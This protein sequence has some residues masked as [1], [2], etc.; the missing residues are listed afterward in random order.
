MSQPVLF[1]DLHGVLVNTPRIFDEY[2]RIT[3]EHL[4]NHLNLSQKD[5]EDRYD[6]ALALWEKEAFDYL[7]NPTKRKIGRE[8]L[9]FLE[10]C[11]RLFPQFLY[12]GLEIDPTCED[13][14]SRPFEF[15]IASKVKALYPEVLD[16]LGQL[17]KQGY[18]M[19]VASSSHSSHIK[20]IIAA[21]DLNDY[22]DSF[23]GFDTLA[24]TKH[25]LKYYR[26]MLHRVKTSPKSSVMIGNSIH[27]ILKPRKLGM[28]TIHINR[29]RKVP[30]DVRKLADLSLKN[31]SLLPTHLD[32][33]Q[34]YI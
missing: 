17:K 31:L 4:V 27:E 22:I 14:R 16:I 34:I 21:N 32:S 28:K 6:G 5:A 30:Y 3:V 29:E 20:G 8:F 1:I 25:T 12:E 13:L 26:Q 24:A 9:E 18:E 7:R 15:S 19:H 23:Y 33:L 2:K 11:D 10:R